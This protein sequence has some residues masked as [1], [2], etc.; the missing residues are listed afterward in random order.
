MKYLGSKNRISKHI[1]PIMLEHRKDRMCWVEP[2]VGGANMIDKVEGWRIGSDLNEYVIALLNEMTKPNFEAPEI[3]ED[4]YND[5]KTNQ[6]KHPKWIVGYAGTQLSFG[7]TWF[8]SYRRDKQGKRNYCLEARN[9][10]NKQS[11]NL[12]GASF[13]NFKYLELP[14]PNNSII[15]CDP[16]YDTKATKG[17]YKDDFNHI[18]FWNWCRKKSNNGHTVF[19][20][21]YNAPTDFECIWQ[22]EMS[23]RM[24]NNA[25]TSKTIEKLFIAP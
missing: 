4:K 5:I 10:V 3:N 19:V 8:G 7:A 24:N 14:I 2:F 23:Q 22:M 21:E 16:P 1:L 6:S 9:N 15:Y 17:K 13:K 25:D 12:I 20:S 18:E 11:K